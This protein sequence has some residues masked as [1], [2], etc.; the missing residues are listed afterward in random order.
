MNG[1][2]IL[3]EVRI[4]IDNAQF[5]RYNEINRAYRRLANGYPASWLRE[6]TQQVASFE[7]EQE[8]Y[9]L[10]IAGMRRITRIWVYGTESGDIRW[11]ELEEVDQQLFENKKR[12]HINLDGEDRTGLPEYFKIVSRDTDQIVISVVP[13]PDADM[14]MKIDFTK[15]VANIGRETIPEMPSAYHDLI[16]ILAAG[17]ILRKQKDPEGPAL[18]S[19]ALEQSAFLMRDAESNKTKNIDRPKKPMLKVGY[20]RRRY[21]S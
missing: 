4:L 6:E 2:E 20:K 12:E 21:Y 9:A 19:D 13:V 11:N 5:T 8:T 18:I 1:E 14:Q 7:G 16:A 17:Y 15:Q 3:N 10:D